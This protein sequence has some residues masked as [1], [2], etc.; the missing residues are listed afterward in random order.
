[1]RTATATLPMP[2]LFPRLYDPAYQA[3]RAPT[4]SPIVNESSPADRFRRLGSAECWADFPAKDRDAWREVRQALIEATR[5]AGQFERSN[6]PRDSYWRVGNARWSV[7]FTRAGEDFHSLRYRQV[8]HAVEQ[9]AQIANR[10][11]QPTLSVGD[12]WAYIA[13]LPT[14]ALAWQPGE[15]G[16][17]EVSRPPDPSIWKGSR[18][19]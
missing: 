9:L 13:N 4:G 3:E 19:F 5:T 17:D 2:A 1:M 8:R 14:E 10:P 15:V 16:D 18:R 11:V 6:G 7:V 12:T